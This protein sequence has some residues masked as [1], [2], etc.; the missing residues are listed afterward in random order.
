M[1]RALS[2]SLFCVVV[3]FYLVNQNVTRSFIYYIYHGFSDAR[4]R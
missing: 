1:K 2:F 4:R 3:A